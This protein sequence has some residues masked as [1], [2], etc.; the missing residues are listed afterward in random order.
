MSCSNEPL[1]K[2]T[3]GVPGE[4]V[5]VIPASLSIISRADRTPELSKINSFS[6]GFAIRGEWSD[7]GSSGLHVA[8]RT[9]YSGIN[10]GDILRHQPEII[11]V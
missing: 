1:E 8:C 2:V 4:R 10:Q 7:C 11:S 3:P 9:T 6:R 5:S